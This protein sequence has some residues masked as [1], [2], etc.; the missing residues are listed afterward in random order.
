[1]RPGGG[2]SRR[3]DSAVID[4]PEPDSPTI[5]TA[6]PAFS[7]SEMPS[8]ARTTPRGVKK[9]VRRSVTERIAGASTR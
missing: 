7:S 2:T 5:P 8:T 9:C 4:L 6:S 3:I 1:M